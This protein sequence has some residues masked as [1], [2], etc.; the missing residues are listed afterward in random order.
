[1]S[2]SPVM[3]PGTI[4]LINRSPMET[5]AEMPYTTKGLLGGIITPMQPAAA[6]S[7]AAKYFVVAPFGHGRD[8]QRANGRHRCR[9]R[10]ADRA[11]KHAG[12]DCGQAYAAVQSAHEFVGQGQQPSRQTARPHKHACRNKKGDGHDGKAVDLR[13]GG[14]R[15]MNNHLILINIYT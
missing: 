14:Q 7:A 5:W 8:G 15:Q 6:T 13:L 4:P 2:T 12:H 10:T 11:E 1:M 3:M 9:P